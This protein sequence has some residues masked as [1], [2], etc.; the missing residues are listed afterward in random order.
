M[1][2]HIAKLPTDAQRFIR[3]VWAQS[4]RAHSVR[5][6][7][8]VV[9]DVIARHTFFEVTVDYFNTT[10]HGTIEAAVDEYNKH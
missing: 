4:G 9:T 8:C 7:L 1:D 10:S 5:K 2:K 6:T 3:S